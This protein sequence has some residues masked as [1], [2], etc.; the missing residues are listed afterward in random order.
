M[1]D[2]DQVRSLKLINNGSKELQTLETNAYKEAKLVTLV[3]LSIIGG[4]IASYNLGFLL[5]LLNSKSSYV[6]PYRTEYLWNWRQPIVYE[7]MIVSQILAGLNF[8][9][10]FCG[11]TCI[12]CFSFHAFVAKKNRQF[13]SQIIIT[14]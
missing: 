14:Q 9:C 12:Q 2:I 7:I 11:K 4:T 6:L 1:E 10:V 13:T 3:M 8:I 5:G